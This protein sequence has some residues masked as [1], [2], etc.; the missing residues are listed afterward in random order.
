MNKKGGVLLYT[1]KYFMWISTCSNINLLVFISYF[2]KKK[3][4]KAF[5]ILCEYLI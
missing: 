2:C 4:A 1:A 3:F 5:E